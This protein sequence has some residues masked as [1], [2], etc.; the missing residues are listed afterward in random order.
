MRVCIS[1]LR[2]GMWVLFQDVWHRVYRIDAIGNHATAQLGSKS[3]PL[4]NIGPLNSGLRLDVLTK[5]TPDELAKLPRAKDPETSEV[6]SVPV[7]LP[8]ATVN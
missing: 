7:I 2:N 4:F 5:G 8:H 1:N 6:Y 3:T